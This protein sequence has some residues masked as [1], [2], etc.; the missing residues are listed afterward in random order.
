GYFG[1]LSFEASITAG[2]IFAFIQYMERF[3][4]PINQVSQNLSIFQQALVAAS[5]V[6]RLIDDGT[7][8]PAQNP[9]EENEITGGRIDFNN[10]TFTAMLGAP[11]ALVGHTGSGKSSIIN[12]FMRFYE[13]EHGEILIDGQSIKKMPKSELKE[14]IGLVLQ[15][16][17]IFY[18]TIESNIKL[19]HP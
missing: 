17:F 8:E 11:V 13:F 10:V 7:L 18:G 16:P 5:R 14:N 12:L 3:F 19:Y 4:E 15:D 6:F 1:L 2:L 9:D